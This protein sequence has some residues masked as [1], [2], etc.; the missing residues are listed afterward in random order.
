MG[1]AQFQRARGWLFV[2]TSHSSVALPTRCCKAWGC[3]RIA[4]RDARAAPQTE[5][6]RLAVHTTPPPARLPHCP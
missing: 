3:T 5:P 2:P 6:T 1:Q 4:A